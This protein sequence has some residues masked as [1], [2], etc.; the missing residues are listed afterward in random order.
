MFK[1]KTS[2]KRIHIYESSKDTTTLDARHLNMIQTMQEDKA[3]ITDLYK[4]HNETANIIKEIENRIATFKELGDI[5]SDNYN[6]AWT[7]NILFTENKRNIEK[8]ILHLQSFKDEIDYYENT[9]DILFKYY[10][11]IDKQNAETMTQNVILPPT[12]ATRSRKKNH[13]PASINILDAFKIASVHSSEITTENNSSNVAIAPIIDKATLVADYLSYIDPTV[14]RNKADDTLGHCTH[15]KLEM[16]CIQQD[17]VTVCPGCGYQESLLVEQNRPLLR[18]PNK[19][20][21]HFSYKRINHFREWCSQVQGKESTDIPEEIFEQILQEIKKEKIQDTRKIT[22]NKM[23]EILKRLRINKY[24]EHI[25]YII[26]R[27]NGVPT[28]HFSLELEDKLCS[29]FKEIQGPFL[30]YCPKDRKNFLS[31]SYVLYKLFQIL[32]KHEYLRFFQ[33]LKSREKL[34]IQDQIFKKIC[35]DLNWP[36]YPSL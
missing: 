6:I 32:G 17:S 23:R 26:N 13:I 18:Q 4:L 10:D 20:A 24:Y 35:E 15:C 9:G 8:K 27:I 25:N 29:M 11:I 16:V 28:P 14:I 12:K 7:S 3:S 21:S 2:K 5:E 36:F 34:S 19:E 1:E 30:K 33:L 31:Y 22:Y